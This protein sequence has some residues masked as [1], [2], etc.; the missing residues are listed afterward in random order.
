MS[1]L[2]TLKAYVGLTQGQGRHHYSLREYHRVLSESKLRGARYTLITALGQGSGGEE[3]V[4]IL[5]M[6]HTFENAEG[7]RA[8]CE[9]LNDFFAKVFEQMDQRWIHISF[10][11]SDR[12]V[13]IK[14]STLDILREA[15]TRIE[16]ADILDMSAGN[17]TGQPQSPAG[18]D[19]PL[20][21][22]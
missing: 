17:G 16:P 3:D 21:D 20:R 12:G 11:V 13:P 8:V 10:F 14:H 15:K 4:T 9:Q 6:D 5:E 22:D 19:R 1:F 18:N 2:L 7:L